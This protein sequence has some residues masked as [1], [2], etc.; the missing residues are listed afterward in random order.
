M[1]N[2]N[3]YIIEFDNIIPDQLVDDIFCEYENATEWAPAQISTGV[4]DPSNRNVSTIALSVHYDN[5]TDIR[6]IIDNQLFNCAS[7][8]IKKYNE[9][10]P[11]AIIAQDSGYD[12]LRYQPGQF[13]KQHTDSVKTIPRSVSCSFILNNDYEGGEFAFFDKE[14]KIKPKKRSALMFP[15]NFMYPHEIMPVTKGI[16]YS[17]VTWFI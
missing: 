1:K 8:A 4:V 9:A 14:L 11:Y 10:F 2:I 12:L 16:R 15:S 13:Y 3:D 7:E 6:K 17:I 5:N